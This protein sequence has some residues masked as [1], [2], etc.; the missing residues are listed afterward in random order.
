VPAD[1][2]W[3]AGRW[4]RAATQE[5]DAVRAAGKVP[6]VVGGTGLYF[7]ALEGGL[8]L[9]PETPANIRTYW[10]NRLQEAGAAALH[11]E[12]AQRAPE[13]AARLE[14]GDSQRIVR[15][16]EVL[17][18]TGKPLS[19]HFADEAPAGPLEGACVRRV[20]LVPPRDLLYERCDARFLAMMSQGAV[21]EIKAL[22][23]KGLSSDLPVMKAIGVG[24]LA[25]LLRNEITQD[26]AIMLA[27]R[28]TRNYAK[29]QMTWI[30][31][32][33][34]SWPRA[35]DGGQAYGL[36]LGE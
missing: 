4:L 29:R 31:N 18:A 13:E 25:A 33:M 34:E 8:S 10:R 2:A 12:L 32:Q 28:Q 5:I 30:R 17:Q 23:S 14:P 6:V 3:S 36:L 24:A 9:V 15:A 21:A 7:K 1:E 20:A 35:E 26:E 27:Q 11:Q 16:L 19:G 22:L